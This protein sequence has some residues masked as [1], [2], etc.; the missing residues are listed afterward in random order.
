M[1]AGWL[2]V[3]SPEPGVGFFAKANQLKDMIAGGNFVPSPVFKSVESVKQVIFNNQ[4]DGVLMAGFM[5]VVV[6]MVIF[7]IA[8]CMKALG[9]DK[10]TAKEIPYEPL[11][12]N[13]DE[14]IKGT[15]H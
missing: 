14:I 1:Y 9:T 7:T 4:L 11:P 3:F 8:S 6:A 2:K 15:A 12:A 10:V 5:V 13:A